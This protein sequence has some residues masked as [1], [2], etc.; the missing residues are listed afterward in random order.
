MA[1]RFQVPH[2]PSSEITP[3]S[4]YVRRRQFM[5]AAGLLAAPAAAAVSF[6]VDAAVTTGG[7]P[8]EFRPANDGR[9][10]FTTR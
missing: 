8:L 1:G 3:E 10:G 9:E 5:Q 4:V 2:I 6:N 7:K